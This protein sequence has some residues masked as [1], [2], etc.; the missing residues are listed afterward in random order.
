M[1]EL[2]ARGANVNAAD[3]FGGTPL[4]LASW[5]GHAEVVQ[6]LLS[7]GADKR[8]MRINGATATELAGAFFTA[9]VSSRA[10]IRALLAA[11]P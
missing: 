5:C 10:A 1:R 8:L 7:A 11:A 9:P 6:A 4:I 3:N 2:L